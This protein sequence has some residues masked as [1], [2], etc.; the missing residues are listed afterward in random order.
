MGLY[1]RI[2]N[3]REELKMTQ[4]ELAIKMGYKSRSTIAKIES[5]ANDIP[6]SKIKDFAEALQTT[7]SYLMGWTDDTGFASEITKKQINKTIFSQRLKEIMEENNETTYTLGDSLHL[8][9]ATISRYTIGEMAPKITTIEILSLKYNINPAWLMGYDV[10]KHIKTDKPNT[11]AAHATKD[12]T[13][14]EQEKVI[15]YIKFLK[16]QRK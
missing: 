11:L 2:K 12:L 5:G 10:P 13:E 9:A 4:E 1:E 15:E 3:R 8:S 6:Q 16:S 14:E 7:P